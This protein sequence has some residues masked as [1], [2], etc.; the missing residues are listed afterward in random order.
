M[1]RE[2]AQYRLAICDGE[3]QIAMAE[4]NTERERFETLARKGGAVALSAPLLFP[5]PAHVARDMV[6]LADIH[7]GHEVLEPSAGMGA[8]IKE[9]LALDLD[10]LHLG[11]HEIDESL[12]KHLRRQ[13]SEQY[14]HPLKDYVG[15]T[16]GDFLQCDKRLRADGVGYDR[17]VMNPPYKRGLDI[18]HILHAREKL[19]PNGVLVGLCYAGNKQ[20]KA[21]KHLCDYWELLPPKSFE[22]TSTDVFMFRMQM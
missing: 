14:T 15:I 3:N 20:I 19:K 9:I 22:G 6:E 10:R 2:D 7:E 4:M 16:H 21:L 12:V 8:I 5:T 1:S 11:A 17:I 13:F 18:K